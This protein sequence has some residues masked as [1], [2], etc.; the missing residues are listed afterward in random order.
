MP[1][2]LMHKAFIQIDR[3]EP[4]DVILTAEHGLLSTFVRRGTGGRYSHAAIYVDANLIFESTGD[5]VGFRPIESQ[6]DSTESGREITL[7]DVSHYA[8]IE[9]FRLADEYR[10]GGVE[11]AAVSSVLRA[12]LSNEYG[13]YYPYMYRVLNASPLPR[14]F[15]PLIRKIEFA[16]K[17][18]FNIG[19]PRPSPGPFCSQLVAICFEALNWKLMKQTV[20]ADRIAPNDLANKKK[21]N[22]SKLNLVIHPFAKVNRMAQGTQSEVGH[23]MVNAFNETIYGR[24]G[25][26]MQ[27]ARRMRNLESFTGLLMVLEEKFGAGIGGRVLLSLVDME[28]DHQRKVM[29]GIGVIVAMADTFEPAVRTLILLSFLEAIEEYR[30]TMRKMTKSDVNDLFSRT[31]ARAESSAEMQRLLNVLEESDKDQA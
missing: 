29:D 14:A 18:L 3:L 20:S 2:R 22:L 21:S 23:A 24:K 9:V 8:A 28:V 4:G 27:S 6:V 25:M 31:L 7:W 12:T 10:L 16:A 11:Q 13:K 17:I 15:L 5:G 26:M 1:A 30:K 19:S